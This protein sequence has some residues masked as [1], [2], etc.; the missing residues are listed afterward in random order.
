MMFEKKQ[1]TTLNENNGHGEWLKSSDDIDNFKANNITEVNKHIENKKRNLRSIIKIDDIEEQNYNNGYELLDSEVTE[2]SS[3][4][5]SSLAYDDVKKVHTETVIAVT[6]DDLNNRKKYSNI[7][8][9]KNE[10]NRQKIEPATMQESRQYLENKSQ[11][12]NNIST[13]RAYELAKQYEKNKEKNKEWWATLKQ[14][15]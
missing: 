3:G 6:N 1:L 12:E 2:Y 11:F 4:L 14:I 5:F 10:R 7:E 15:T 8:Q 13:N 9:L